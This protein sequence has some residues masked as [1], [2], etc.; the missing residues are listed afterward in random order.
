MYYYIQ[1]DISL[2]KNCQSPWLT[3]KVRPFCVCINIVSS[4]KNCP[5]FQKNVPIRQYSR[6]FF[7][8]VAEGSVSPRAVVAVVVAVAVFRIEGEPRAW[9]WVRPKAH[10]EFE[11]ADPNFR[12]PCCCCTEPTCTARY[13]LGPRTIRTWIR[14]RRNRHHHHLRTG[15]LPGRC[16]AGKELESFNLKKLMWN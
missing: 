8:I 11:E 9:A 3:S 15:Y 10:P 12:L 2:L 16:G 14:N 4:L 13:G 6:V 1:A 7:S 5:A